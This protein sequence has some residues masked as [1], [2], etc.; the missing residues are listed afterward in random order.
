MG[1]PIVCVVKL[2]VSG[3]L[4]GTGL[5][6]MNVVGFGYSL[7]RALQTSAHNYLHRCFGCLNNC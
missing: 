6:R 3:F 4:V 7:G 1:S 5:N 2:S